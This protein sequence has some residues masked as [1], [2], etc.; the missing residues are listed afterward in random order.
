MTGGGDNVN[1]GR[2]RDMQKNT[3]AF[4][5]LLESGPGLVYMITV[6]MLSTVAYLQMARKKKKRSEWGFLM[7][8]V[9]FSTFFSGLLGYAMWK[10]WI[11]AIPVKMFFSVL[12]AIPGVCLSIFIEY[13]CR[14]GDRGATLIASNSEE[15]FARRIWMHALIGMVITFGLIYIIK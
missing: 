1:A 7:W 9:F 4:R 14:I 5:Q 2:Y 12:F 6:Q 10:K 11:S 15:A 3:Q 8:H 13:T